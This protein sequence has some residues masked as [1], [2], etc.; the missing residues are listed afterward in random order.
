MYV[1]LLRVLADYVIFLR[2]LA[3]CE[4]CGQ[5]SLCVILLRVL[6]VC[7]ILLRVLAVGVG[8]GEAEEGAYHPAGGSLQ[9]D[10][11]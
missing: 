5:W 9:V 1:I 2:M 4:Y 8:A 7:V 11:K 6:V 3:V 10:Q